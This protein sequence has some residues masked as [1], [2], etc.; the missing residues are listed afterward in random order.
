MKKNE[1]DHTKNATR[2]NTQIIK[3]K[4]TESNATYVNRLGV[5]T[6]AA[7]EKKIECTVRPRLHVSKA[8][9]C[10]GV[11]SRLNAG[12]AFVLYTICNSRIDGIVTP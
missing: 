9:F 1:N 4:E 6:N 10:I 12:F 7:C 5:K 8:D 3:V 11:C 2:N